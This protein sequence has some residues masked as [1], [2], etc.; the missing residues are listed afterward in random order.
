M[1]SLT[2]FLHC[3]VFTIYR[4]NR[5][6]FDW[7]I[8]VRSLVLCT[9]VLYVYMYIC[10]RIL[11]WW[12]NCVKFTFPLI[13]L[14]TKPLLIKVVWVVCLLGYHL[15]IVIFSPWFPFLVLFERSSSPSWA[16][17]RRLCT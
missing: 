4:R 6:A 10:V 5:V 17:A 9:I 1:F 12:F 14:L 7:V 11:L 2:G 13:Y 16:S 3:H 15:L 8:M